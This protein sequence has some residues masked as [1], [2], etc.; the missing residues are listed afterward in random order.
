MATT[1]P[2]ARSI[3]VT[4]RALRSLL[5]QRLLAAKLSFAQWAVLNFLHAAG[6]LTAELRIDP[7]RTGFVAE[8]GPAQQAVDDLRARG[9]IGPS[10]HP[11]QPGGALAITALGRELFEP[12]RIGSAAVT[13]ELWGDLPA[14]DLDATHRTLTEIGRRAN[15]RLTEAR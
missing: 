12:L 1:P 14:A 2:L 11:D 6:P 9:L 13:Q 7:Q 10:A 8:A 3:G 15:L 4:E 5:D